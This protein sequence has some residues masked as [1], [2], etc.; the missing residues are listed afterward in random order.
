MVWSSWVPSL[1]IYK[2]NKV[3]VVEPSGFVNGIVECDWVDGAEIVVGAPPE[4]VEEQV[5]HD[6]VRL[7]VMVKMIDS[8]QLE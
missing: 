5:P 7:G 2:E 1:I 4:V 6:P 8:T 3:L